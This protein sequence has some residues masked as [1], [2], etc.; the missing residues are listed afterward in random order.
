MSTTKGNAVNI[1][2]RNSFLLSNNFKKI[3]IGRL[4]SKFGL[5]LA[6]FADS[7]IGSR[8][9]GT[10]GMAAVGLY[11]PIFFLDEMLHSLF[12]NGIIFIYTRLYGQGEKEKAHRAFTAVLIT[13]FIAYLLIFIPLLLF[14]KQFIAFYTDTE[15]LTEM[16]YTYFTPM[17]ISLPFFE[18]C[19]ITEN[20]FT[21]DGRPLFFSMRSII[22]VLLNIVLDLLFIMKFSWGTA[23]LAY[24]TVLSTFIGYLWSLSHIFNKQKTVKLSFNVCKNMKEFWAYV[25]EELIIGCNFAFDDG[26]NTIFVA[27]LNKLVMTLGGTPAMFALSLFSGI[28]TI[29]YRLSY[30]L[31]NSVNILAGT[32]YGEEDF[33]GTNIIMKTAAKTSVL[34][35]TTC[36][37]LSITLS[38]FYLQFCHITDPISYEMCINAFLISSWAFPCMMFEKVFKSGL[39]I[40]KNYTIIKAYCITFCG[41]QIISICALKEFLGINAVWL[42]LAIANYFA[43]LITIFLMRYKNQRFL[44]LSREHS[45]ESF[46]TALNLKTIGILA[47]KV[48]ETILNN[49]Y[50]AS[51][52][53]H[54]SLFTEEACS[55]IFHKNTR[56]VH[57]DLRIVATGKNKEKIHISICDNGVVCN[58]ATG[59]MNTIN[60][61]NNNTELLLLKGFSDSYT[62]NRITN[63]NYT[64]I[65]CK[66]KEE[67]KTN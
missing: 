17:L 19:L 55:Y 44:P 27:I 64:R 39:I 62:Y 50:S 22:T 38:P 60:I 35:G 28:R 7:V 30:G 32:L 1:S 3:L 4:I 18:I 5:I 16:A 61:E 11:M 12:G 52:A 6:T 47:L 20:V 51:M 21:I 57:L 58:P 40:F 42:T 23:G 36:L 59:I 54:I 43:I 48:R 29:V 10:Y 45:I 63:L 67:P 25:K 53:N 37:L 9:L 2:S 13:T 66:I 33:E 41:L 31:S 46:S 56:K 65:D 8:F 26:L 49:G 34:L 24:A 14:A 15:I